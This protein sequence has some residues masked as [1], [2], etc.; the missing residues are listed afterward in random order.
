MISFFKS[1]RKKKIYFKNIIKSKYLIKMWE[2]GMIVY[3]KK[4]KYIFGID[5]G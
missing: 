5:I 4:L 1:K 3:M 2:I